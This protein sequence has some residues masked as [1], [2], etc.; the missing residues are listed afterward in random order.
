MFGLPVAWL[1]GVAGGTL[2]LLA[3]IGVQTYRVSDA[4]RRLAET[5]KT[6]IRLQDNNATLIG[7]ETRLKGSITEQ[8]AQIQ[9]L[10]AEGETRSKAAMEELTRVR[11]T[12]TARNRSLVAQLAVRMPPPGVDVCVAALA[13]ARSPNL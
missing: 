4:Q 8:N 6:V 3:G 5:E 10:K 12:L 11:N 9:A 13:E 1:Y 7:N 2:L